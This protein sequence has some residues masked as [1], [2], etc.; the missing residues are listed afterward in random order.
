M[1][2]NKIIKNIIANINELPTLPTVVD[3]LNRLLQNPK[4]SAEEVGKAIITDQAIASKVIKLVNSAFYGFPGKITTITHAIVIL[5][6]STV[7]NIVLTA[8]I[9]GSIDSKSVSNKSFS[10]PDF[11]MHSISTGA[12]AL[13]IGKY[14]KLPNE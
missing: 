6:F 1:I 5:G 7:R 9:I 14:F 10:L 12:F 8:S 4:T 3:E 2:E 13:T 11:W